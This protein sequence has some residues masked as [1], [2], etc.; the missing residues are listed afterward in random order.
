MRVGGEPPPS[1]RKILDTR[2]GIV[3]VSV[4]FEF[5]VAVSVLVVNWLFL[6]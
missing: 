1:T 3:L 6:M 4:G 2:G 5:Y